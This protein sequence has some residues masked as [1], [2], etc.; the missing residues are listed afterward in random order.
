MLACNAKRRQ[1]VNRFFATTLLFCRDE[2]LTLL[3]WAGDM[4][5]R[6]HNGKSEKA[7]AQEDI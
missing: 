1:Y 2:T 6:R 5:N 4:D 7:T 3:R